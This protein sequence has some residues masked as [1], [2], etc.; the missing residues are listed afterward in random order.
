MPKTLSKTDHR[1]PPKVPLSGWQKPMQKL[2][3]FGMG[4]RHDPPIETGCGDMAK[5]KRRSA[6]FGFDNPKFCD[7]AARWRS[8]HRC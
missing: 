1:R 3:A 5:A 2:I 4:W 8:L 6:P 7:L